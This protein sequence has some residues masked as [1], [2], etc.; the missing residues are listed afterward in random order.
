MIQVW[1]NEDIDTVMLLKQETDTEI[2]VCL[3]NP[4]QLHT[5]FTTVKLNNQ[6]KVT[7][8]LPPG[9]K[10]FYC[11]A[12]HV[13]PHGDRLPLWETRCKQRS[14]PSSD[15]TT[16]HRAEDQDVSD[17]LVLCYAI[18]W[19]KLPVQDNYNFSLTVYYQA[20][21]LTEFSIIRCCDRYWNIWRKCSVVIFSI[22]NSH[23]EL[24]CPFNNALYSVFKYNYKLTSKYVSLLLFLTNVL[25]C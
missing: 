20:D 1:T 7:R 4:E 11:I 5:C 25:K 2:L 24:I 18:L 17:L 13:F 12:T 16:K 8:A 19:S 23:N 15:T 22:L 21:N 14:M 3:S 6:I 10:G 9:L